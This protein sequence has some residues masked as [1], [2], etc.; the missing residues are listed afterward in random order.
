M[1]RAL[2]VIS[3]DTVSPC[4]QALP[5]FLAEN[6]YRSPT[7]G[8]KSSFQKAHST[9][10]IPFLWLQDKPTQL[11]NFGLWA[12]ASREGQ[13]IFLDVF[14]FERELAS[15]TRP[16]TP[17]FVDVGGGIGPQCVALKQRLL[18][19]PGRVILQD[20]PPV[21]AHA[22]PFE[23]VEPMAHDFMTEQPI[24]GTTGRTK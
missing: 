1:E 13:K 20:Q 18:N 4:W 21:L 24:K 22:I 6:G 16:E 7:D 23:A 2:T 14:P 12:G 19:V 15:N 5:S 11:K 17:L 9:D 3:H 10:L 8:A